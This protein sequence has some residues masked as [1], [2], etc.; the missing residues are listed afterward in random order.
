MLIFKGLT[1]FIYNDRICSAITM[2]NKTNVI[3][4]R[5]HE[6]SIRSHMVTQYSCH[7]F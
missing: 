4:G 6:S 1:E 7:A 2:F 5:Y 3:T